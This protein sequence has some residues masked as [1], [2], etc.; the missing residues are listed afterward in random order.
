SF[1]FDLLSNQISHSFVFCSFELMRKEEECFYYNNRFQEIR[2]KHFSQ[3]GKN[4][5][6]LDKDETLQCNK[7]ILQRLIIPQLRR[8]D[9]VLILLL[10]TSIALTLTLTLTIPTQ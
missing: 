2:K 9:V 7:R 3:N 1:V 4:H 5:K 10:L 8:P 6:Q